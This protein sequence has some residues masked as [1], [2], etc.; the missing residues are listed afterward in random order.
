MFG[1][2]VLNEAADTIRYSHDIDIS[3][4]KPEI[5][6]QSALDDIELLKTAGFEVVIQVG[7]PTFYRAQVLHGNQAVL[8]KWVQDSA[9]RFFPVGAIPRLVK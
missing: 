1:A 5:V 7:R 3:H 4:D 8:L 2:T 9:F 6:A